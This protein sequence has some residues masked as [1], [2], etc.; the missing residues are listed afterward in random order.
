MVDKQ[1]NDRVPI[2]ETYR[3]VG[4]H[5]FQ[6]PERLAK[7][8]RSIDDVN[9]IDDIQAL[10]DYAANYPNPPEARLLASWRCEALWEDAVRKRLPH[11]NLDVLKLRAFVA[12]LSSFK[13]ISPTHYGSDLQS[14]DQ[15]PRENEIT[16]DELEAAGGERHDSPYA[17]RL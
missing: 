10:Y 2:C 12:G 9:A 5:I 4:L 1:E 6:S 11:P 13:W 14:G 17:P 16:D 3:G 8:R 7:V 15:E